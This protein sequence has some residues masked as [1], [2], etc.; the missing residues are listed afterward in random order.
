MK[1]TLNFLLISI[2]SINNSVKKEEISEKKSIK[3]KKIK[4]VP[5]PALKNKNFKNT[6]KEKLSDLQL[7]NKILKTFKKYFEEDEIDEAFKYLNNRELL[8]IIYER[9]SK[10]SILDDEG[11]KDTLDEDISKKDFLYFSY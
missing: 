4:K 2:F 6:S 7:K 1:K 5:G 9:F 11:C 3:E 10:K 8:K